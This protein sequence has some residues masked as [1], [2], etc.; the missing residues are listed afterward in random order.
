MGFFLFF[1][2]VETKPIY[3]EL[4]PRFRPNMF[5]F[6]TP[7]ENTGFRGRFSTGGQC[8]AGVGLPP[9]AVRLI[10]VTTWVDAG[11]EPALFGS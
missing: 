9:I 7:P 5:A 3:P 4:V 10:V 2:G 8:T 11:I 1:F 6:F